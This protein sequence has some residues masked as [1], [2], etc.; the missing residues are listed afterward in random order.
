[1]AELLRRR[2]IPASSV[3]GNLAA[4]HRA[5]LDPDMRCRPRG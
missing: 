2:G 5:A 3:R 4:V 1:L